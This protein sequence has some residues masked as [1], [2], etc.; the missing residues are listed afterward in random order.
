MRRKIIPYKPYLKELARKLR[1]NGTLSE[2]RLWQALKGKRLR[3]YDFHRQKPL[4]KF[5][6]DFYC[7]EL[8]LVI[9]LDGATH[10]D[11]VV[12][13]KDKIKEDR[14]NELG[15]TVLR[16]KDEEVITDI[17]DVVDRIDRYISLYEEVHPKEHTP[18][19]SRE[20]SL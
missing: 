19:P 1:N 15:L 5:I 3:G 17:G 13:E 16:F 11:P 12:Q 14:L 7:Y 2:K 6:A 10:L 18:G 8:E 20:G 4:D 9:E